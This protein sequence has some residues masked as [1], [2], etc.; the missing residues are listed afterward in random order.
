MLLDKIMGGVFKGAVGTAKNVAIGAAQGVSKRKAVGAILDGIEGTAQRQAAK[1][2]LRMG[3]LGAIPRAAGYVA[4]A[5]ARVAAKTT[6]ATARGAVAMAKGTAPV[7]G[8]VGR[9]AMKDIKTMT[10][11]GAGAVKGAGAVLTEASEHGRTLGNL[12]TG[13]QWKKSAHWGI[14]LAVP[15]GAGAV[16][17]V[18]ANNKNPGGYQAPGVRNPDFMG[19][20]QVKNKVDYSLGATG[21]L[22]TSLHAKRRG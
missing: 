20:D 22:V 14:S 21:D 2:S 9:S 19:Y 8:V 1:E 7:L 5:G 11:I 10:G 13:R 16:A 3:A 17:M 15:V 12:F 18:A 4:G 6:S